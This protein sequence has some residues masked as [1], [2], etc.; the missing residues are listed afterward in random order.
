MKYFAGTVA[1]AVAAAGA[2]CAF[3]ILWFAHALKKW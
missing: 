1:I 3:R 2:Y